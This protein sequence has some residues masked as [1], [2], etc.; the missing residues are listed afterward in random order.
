MIAYTRTILSYIIQYYYNTILLINSAI[1]GNI[2]Q[3]ATTNPLLKVNSA[4][5]KTLRG[6]KVQSAGNKKFF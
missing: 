3:P 1:N 5:S 4:A 2:A 6:P